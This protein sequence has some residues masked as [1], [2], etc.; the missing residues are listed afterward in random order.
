M[1]DIPNDMECKVSRPLSRSILIRQVAEQT[2]QWCFGM[3]YLLDCKMARS[4]FSIVPAQTG[5]CEEIK[6]L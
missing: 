3:S 5:A 1:H 4:F 2:P 6:V